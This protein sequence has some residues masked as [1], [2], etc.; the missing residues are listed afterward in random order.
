VKKLKIETIFRKLCTPEGV[1][2]IHSLGHALS[3]YKI[4]FDIPELVGM[5]ELY[6]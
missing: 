1:I 6:G 5:M 4:D 2:T 3:K